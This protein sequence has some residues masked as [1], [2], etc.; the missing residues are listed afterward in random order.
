MKEAGMIEG[1]DELRLA[2]GERPF[3]SAISEVGYSLANLQS[4]IKGDEA[5]HSI[6]VVI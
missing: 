4:Q 5:W 3:G 6:H 1:N 2:T